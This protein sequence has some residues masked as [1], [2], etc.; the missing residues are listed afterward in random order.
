MITDDSP[1]ACAVCLSGSEWLGALRAAG[2]ARVTAKAAD[3]VAWHRMGR[4]PA[5]GARPARRE[6]PHAR[7]P[8]A[9]DCG[10]CARVAAQQQERGHTP[11]QKPRAT[12]SSRRE[13][14]CGARAVHGG[15]IAR[16]ARRAHR[17]RAAHLVTLGRR[18]RVA[19][20]APEHL[21]AG[22]RAVCDA[23]FRDEARAGVA[24]LAVEHAAAKRDVAVLRLRGYSQRP[25]KRGMC[26]GDGWAAR[27]AGRDGRARKGV[28][29]RSDMSSGVARGRSW[30][31]GAT[32]RGGGVRA[33]ARA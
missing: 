3:A 17:R 23:R 26:R 33:C 28:W 19:C 9:G 1:C 11:R 13:G 12:L 10:D 16:R 22:E 27:V 21:R 24:D 2:S 5:R 15:R 14:R 8:G 20:L 30:E 31:V 32:E 18:R 25:C 6:A 4:R 7:W 29:S